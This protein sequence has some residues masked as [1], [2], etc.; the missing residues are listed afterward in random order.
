MPV[1]VAGI[2]ADYEP[3]FALAEEFQPIFQPSSPRQEALGRI[4]IIADAAHSFGAVQKGKHAGTIADFSA[5]SFHAVKNLTTGEGG[6]LVW[7]KGLPFDTE[8]LYHELQL[9]SLHGQNKDA[10]AK[11]Q[12]GAWEYDIVMPGYKCNM[13]DTLAALGLSQLRR[14]DAVIERR[15]EIIRRYHQVVVDECGAEALAHDGQDFHSSG[16][17][18]ICRLPGFDVAGRN[19]F[20]TKM[21]ELGVATNVHYKPLPRMTAYR[22]LGYE[23]EDYPNADAFYT[24]EVTLP[25]HTCLTDEDVDYV[26]DAFRSVWKA[27]A[28]AK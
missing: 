25:L 7:R 24:N 6:A 8:T 12:L 10:L 20:I 26:C 11:T 14:Y 15:H 9:W 23:I 2:V 5:F 22:A 3:Y 16:H 1:D 19:A 21:A 13:P 27:Y 17:L 28:P 4:A 18:Y